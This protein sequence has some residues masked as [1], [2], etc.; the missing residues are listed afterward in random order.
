MTYNKTIQDMIHILKMGVI[1]EPHNWHQE[2]ASFK[3]IQTLVTTH[4]TINPTVLTNM[5]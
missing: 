3:F 2:S 5:K 1:S 4:T